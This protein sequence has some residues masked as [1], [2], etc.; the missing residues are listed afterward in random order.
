MRNKKIVV[1]FIAVLAVL[2]FSVVGCS[3]PADKK[4]EPSKATSQDKK[5]EKK[6]VNLY[7]TRHYDSDKEL[8]ARF[9]KETGIKVNVVKEKKAGALI[10][11]IKT[12]GDNVQ[13]DLFIT[14]D[15]GNLAKASSKG[16]LDVVNS[17]VL[18]KNIPEKYRDVNNKWFGLT[19]R[20]RIMLYSKERVK[21][22]ELKKLNYDN[23]ATDK[24]WNKKVLVRSSSSIY[25]QSL[26][27]S[28]I[29]VLGKEKATNWVENL[30]KQFARKPEGNDRDQALAIKKGLG[31]IAI[32]NSYYYGKL[33]N[34]K[35]SN[36][37]YFGV[38]D[39]VGIYFPNND[40]NGVHVNVSGIG[41]IKNAKNKEAAIKFMEFLSDVKQQEQFSSANYEFPVNPKAKMSK[42]LQ[43]WLDNQGIKT[44]NE[45]KINLSSLGSNNA[46]AVK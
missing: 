30:V 15:A 20:A 28:F 3:K 38:A 25:N 18:K 46:E 39:V 32:S 34:D 41:L 5:T 24:R 12:Q 44:L 23:L 14:A 2:A 16:I 10:E 37:K 33:V 40:K 8:Y 7:T 13:A 31:D 43:S 21:E 17:D 1:L 26:V 6:E 35:D 27:A 45:Q 11:K 42:L 4:A 36:S 19:K 22:E 9:E 29:E